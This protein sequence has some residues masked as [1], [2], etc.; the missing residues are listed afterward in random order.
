MQIEKPEFMDTEYV[1]YDDDG[2]KIKE[3]SP[4]WVKDAY[5]EFMEELNGGVIK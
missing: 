1:Y 5:N 2:L 4:K 3:D